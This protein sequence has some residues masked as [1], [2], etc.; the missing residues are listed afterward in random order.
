MKATFTVLSCHFGDPFWVTQ[1]VNRVDRFSTLE[2]VQSIFLVDQ[3]RKDAVSKL[4]TLPR[5]DRIVRYPIDEAQT[6][7]LGHDHPASLDRV[8]REII[9]TSHVL[10]MD[11]DTLLLTEKWQH[12]LDAA[13]SRADCVL[14]GDSKW[15]LSH[16][17]FMAIP[18]EA[19]S[20][21]DFSAGVIPLGIDTGRLVGYQ[22]S[23]AGFSVDIM[24]PVRA[25]K[26]L[27]GDH[28]LGASILHVGS[29]SFASATDQKL[30]RRARPLSD[31][32]VRR[33][34]S[35]GSL[36]FTVR[37]RTCL[38]FERLARLVRR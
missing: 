19:L 37:D 28:Y 36:R 29:A 17:C 25:F 1:M 18:V 2:R 24:R 33:R 5:V 27:R 11:S 14:A 3:N 15:G 6:A 22:L 21:C 32:V 9:S 35:D 31:S 26:G 20:Y 13:L 12:L 16:P 30:R 23:T 8:C 7:M 34:V 4:G 38:L 10:I